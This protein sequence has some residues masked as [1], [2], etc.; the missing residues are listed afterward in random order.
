MINQSNHKAAHNRASRPCRPPYVSLLDSAL[1]L[2]QSALS[3]ANYDAEAGKE[4]K[5][6][7]DRACG[8]LRTAPHLR[9]NLRQCL[10]KQQQELLPA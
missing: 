9:T 6:A 3:H 10:P 5:I 2:S 7:A 8:W 1:L 4:P